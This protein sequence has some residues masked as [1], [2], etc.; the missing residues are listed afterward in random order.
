M[1]IH[2]DER[3]GEYGDH[4][5][6][7][8]PRRP[9]Y[10]MKAV[11]G[12]VGL[13]AVLGTGAYVVTARLAGGTHTTVAPENGALAPLAPVSAV[14]S[15][16]AS[17]TPQVSPAPASSSAKPSPSPPRD[18]AKVRKEID[19]ARAQAAADGV[20]LQP[21]LT[22]KKGVV[23]VAESITMEK[24]PEGTIRIGTARGDLTGQGTRLIAADDGEPAGDDGARC[25]QRVRFSGKAAIR[26]M[27]T[28]LLCWRT[29]AKRSV[30]TLAVASHGRPSTAISLAVI[31]REWAKLG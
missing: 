31:N 14:P 22:P 15:S 20:Q 23:P 24:T 10:R 19:A 7:T 16:P 1:S 27:P 6:A 18:E 29:S 4:P 2:D 13:A 26:T 17:P 28:M 9:T 5:Y 21:A 3:S 12:V 30:V 11:A 8:N 25:T